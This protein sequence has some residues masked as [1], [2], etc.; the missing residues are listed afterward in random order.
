MKTFADLISE[1]RRLEREHASIKEI[2]SD[3]TA[4]KGELMQ[5]SPP[6]DEDAARRVQLLSTKIDLC[7]PKLA[8]VAAQEKILLDTAA[9]VSQMA[10]RRIASRAASMRADE[11][12]EWQTFFASR[13]PEAWSYPSLR[14]LIPL[15]LAYRAAYQL[16]SEFDGALSCQGRDPIR[17]WT[18]AAQLLEQVE[19]A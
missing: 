1:K 14:T 15:S 8:Q 9:S 18:K 13:A 6:G 10:R 2:E 3:S 4:A 11:D 7:K 16:E 19:Q 17:A 12:R 5:S